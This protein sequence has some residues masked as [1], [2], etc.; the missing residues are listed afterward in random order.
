MKVETVETEDPLEGLGVNTRQD[1]AVAQSILRKRVL[2]NLM[3]AGVTVVDP[4]TTYV[5]ANVKIGYDTIIHPFTFIEGNVRIGKF[6]Q[7]GPFARIRPGTR[8]DDKVEIRNFTEVS[9]SKVGNNTCMKHF[10]YLGD[11]VVGKN[12]NIGAGV[13]TANFD[14][15]E[16]NVTRIGDRAFIGSGSVVIAPGKIGKKAIVG[17]GSV[18]T[19]GKTIP[20]GGVA[21]GIPA[22]VISK[23]K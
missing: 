7:I 4:E 11:S 16:K 23:G 12:V 22:Q 21:V 5:D 13:V 1:L 17:A 19:K 10:S 2:S 3:L 15:V 20:D 9:R 14:G 8:I 18:V 6:C